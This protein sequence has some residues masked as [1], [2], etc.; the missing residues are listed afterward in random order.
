[1]KLSFPT[2]LLAGALLAS[3]TWN[4]ARWRIAAA[5]GSAGC[6]EAA[7]RAD[8]D[9][10][11]PARR[12]RVEQ[13]LRECDARCGRDDARAATLSRELFDLLRVEAVDAAAVRA[14]AAELGALRS[15]AVTASAEAML[16]LRAELAAGDFGRVL[17][18][19]CGGSCSGGTCGSCAAR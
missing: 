12:A 2:C 7:A 10:A 13:L 16:A 3:L 11:D 6:A 5:P 1:M 4:L 9:L 19:C 8:L 18:A 15:G 14:K 17:D